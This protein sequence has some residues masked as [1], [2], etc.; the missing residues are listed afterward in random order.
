SPGVTTAVPTIKVVSPVDGTVVEGSDL[1]VRVETTGLEFVDPS[2]TTVPGQGHVH[3]TL[4]EQPV[5][6]SVTPDYTLKNIT[7]GKHTLRSEL[8][9]NDTTPFAPAVFQTVTFTVK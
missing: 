7:P 2:N 9:Q 1:S 4:D 3:F 6:M 8:V 5:Q